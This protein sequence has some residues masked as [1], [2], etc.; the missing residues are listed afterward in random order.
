MIINP[1]KNTKITTQKNQSLIDMEIGE[2]LNY[3]PRTKETQVIYEELLTFIQY[4]L[5]DQTHETIK[6]GL[7]EVV[8]CQLVVS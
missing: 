6:G 3:K 1:K 5:E 8:S 2:Q 4:K 7:D